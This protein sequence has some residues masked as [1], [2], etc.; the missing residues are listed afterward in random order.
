[1]AVTG[2]Q[3]QPDSPRHSSYWK[4]NV[5]ILN[6]EDFLSNFIDLYNNLKEDKEHHNDAADWWE[7]Q[8]KPMIRIFLK[9]YSSM[10]KRDKHSTKAMLYSM[11]SNSIN[12]G[13]YGFKESLQLKKR[14]SDMIHLETESVK[15][16][17]RFKENIK[18]RGDHFFI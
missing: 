3:R 12:Q 14:I 11:L 13:I 2:I 15:I 16:R 4:L 9:K 10:M 7:Y 1:M 5:S 6:D 17:S 18:R 8:V